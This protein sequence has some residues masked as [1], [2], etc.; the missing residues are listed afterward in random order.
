[1]AE[2]GTGRNVLIGGRGRNHLKVGP[3]GDILIA[4]STDYD[5][6]LDALREILRQW[7]APDREYSQRVARLSGLQGGKDDSPLLAPALVHHSDGDVLQ[8]GPNRDWFLARPA[9]TNGDTI[10][11]RSAG[12]IVTGI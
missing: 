5:A 1:V 6:N 10:K 2:G 3:R 8:R 12:A 4:G 7:A 11:G 9:T